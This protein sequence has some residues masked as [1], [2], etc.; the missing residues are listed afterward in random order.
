VTVETVDKVDQ[1]PLRGARVVHPNRAIT[2][3]RGIAEVR[4]AKGA[5]KLFVSQARYVTFGLPVE[6]TADMTTR[7]ELDPE[8]VTERN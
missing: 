2:E 3:D 8:P 7:A 6:V 5:Y 4:V 1:T